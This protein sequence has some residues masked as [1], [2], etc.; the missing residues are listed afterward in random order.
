[1]ST[2]SPLT[3]GRV[4]LTLATALIIDRNVASV[5]ILVQVLSGFGMHRFAKCSH[6][7][8]AK[9]TIGERQI[10]LVVM[11]PALEEGAGYD[12]VRWLRV[13]KMDPNSYVPI[14]LVTGHTQQH[15]VQ[16]GLDAGASYVIVKP[17]SPAVLLE[18]ILW[19]AHEN[20]SFIETADYLGPD[21]RVREGGPPAG[22]PERRKAAPGAARALRPSEVE[23]LP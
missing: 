9:R 6:V 2:A 10:D 5:N 8:E 22:T 18:R 4:N 11:D 14:I 21:R 12:F 3:T 16:R 7:D 17:V 1:M 19:I 20:K 13:Q 15:N 23:V